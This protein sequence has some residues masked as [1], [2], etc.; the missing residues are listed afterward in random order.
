[1]RVV[2]YGPGTGPFTAEILGRLPPDGHYLGIEQDRVFY[3]LLRERFPSAQFHHGS[4]EDLAEILEE[5]QWP[6]VDHIVSGLPFASFPRDLVGRVLEVTARSLCAGGTFT[7]FQYIHAYAMRSAR[8]VRRIMRRDFQLR[9]KRRV[10]FRNL[11]PAFV[12]TWSK[13]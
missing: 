9:Q 7:T 1:M 5:R 2:E 13:S 4:V 11:P 10:V 6:C 3:S 12:L 8:T